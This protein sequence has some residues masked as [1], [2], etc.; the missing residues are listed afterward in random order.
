[1]TNRSIEYTGVRDAAPLLPSWSF[2]YRRGGKRALDLTLCMLSLPLVLV[3]LGAIW[4]IGQFSGAPVFYCQDRIGRNGQRFRLYKLRTM[5]PNAD[6]AILKLLAND[7]ATATEWQA[8]QKLQNDPRISPWGTFL[9]RS[10][11]DEL[12]QI[13]N[14]LKGDM[15]LVGPR[16]FLPEQEEIYRLAGGRTYFKLRPG[17]TGSWQTSHARGASPFKLRAGFDERYGA[18]CSLRFD[19]A[20][21]LKTLRCLWRLS[22]T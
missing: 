1:M 16:P 12:P 15:S 6:K 21:I 4:A 8:N 14:V 2:S 22:G 20:L 5:V 10:S 13:F 7:P 9:R 19:L 11:L 18:Q 3:I 17:L